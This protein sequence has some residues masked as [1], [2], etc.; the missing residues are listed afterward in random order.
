MDRAIVE[1]YGKICAV[2]VTVE[3]MKADNMLRDQLNQ[4]PA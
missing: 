4:S 2:I 1:L 3:G